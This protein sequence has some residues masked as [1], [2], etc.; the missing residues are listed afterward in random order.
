MFRQPQSFK[1]PASFQLRV[2]HRRPAQ[3]T[4]LGQG[5]AYMRLLTIRPAISCNCRRHRIATASS[6][7]SQLQWKPPIAPAEPEGGG[8]TC[9]LP[10]S[11]TMD[12]IAPTG[13]RRSEC[14][15]HR[16]ERLGAGLYY[17]QAGFKCKRLAASSSSNAGTRRYRVAV[18]SCS[19]RRHK[20]PAHHSG[21]RES[22]I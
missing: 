6:Q 16:H 2:F 21:S 4:S 15:P 14:S 9:G 5:T 13:S 17:K 8:R 18:V 1:S 11:S 12:K 3:F 19:L 7:Q 22:S 10:A 20:K